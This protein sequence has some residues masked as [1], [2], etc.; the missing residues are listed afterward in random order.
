M[1]S[2]VLTLLKDRS[3]ARG[4]L[5]FDEFMEIALFAPDVGYYARPAT[6][7]GRGRGTD[8]FTASSLGP[9]FGELIVAAACSLLGEARAAACTFYEIGAEPAA[10]GSPGRGVLDGVAHPF[11]ATQV[12]PLGSALAIAGPAIVFSNELFDAQPCRRFRFTQG[13]WEEWGV[14]VGAS[15]LEEGPVPCALLPQVLPKSAPEG[16]RLDLPLDA[17]ALAGRICGGGW[18][19]LFLAADYGKSW[20]ELATHCPQG[21]VRAYRAHEQSNDLLATPGEQDLTCHVCWDWLADELRR[22]GFREPV[23]ESQEAFLVRRAGPAL[24][25]VMEQEAA[26]VSARKMALLQLLHPGNMG[27]KFQVLSAL[28]ES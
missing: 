28:R 7:V 22:A 18:T 15:G 8:F 23:V 1:S 20:L 16:Y 4:W 13:A 5:R 27:Q 10:D 6:R 21:T 2:S 3:A 11:R 17:A 26:R 24:A 9:I 12:L 19:G 25:R 14:R